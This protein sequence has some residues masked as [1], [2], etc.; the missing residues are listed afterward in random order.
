VLPLGQLWYTHVSDGVDYAEFHSRSYDAV[1]G[2]HDDAGNVIETHQLTGNFNTVNVKAL[3]LR[4]SAG[5]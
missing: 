1:T 5:L 2:V 3:L 4:R